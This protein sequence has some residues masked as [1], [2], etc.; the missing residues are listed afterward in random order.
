MSIVSVDPFRCR[1]WDLHD[2]LEGA[3]TEESCKAEI[4]SFQRH[5]QIVP[6]LGRPTRG[7][8]DY[9]VDLI[10][11]ARR[12]FIARHLGRALSIELRE[13]SDRDALIAMDAENR[14]RIDISPYERGMSYAQWLRD[15]HFRSQEDI[16]RTLKVSAAQV[17]RL[18][19]FARLPAVVVDAFRSPVEICEAWGCEMIDALE[20]PQWR[21]LII[22]RARALGARSPRPQ[23][24]EVYRQLMATCAKGRRARAAGRDQV[25]KSDRGRPLF[26]VRRLR[27][28]VAL[29]LPVDRVPGTTLSAIQRTLAEMLQTSAAE[30]VVVHSSSRLGDE[31]S[32]ASMRRA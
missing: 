26:R 20:R 27:N 28:H 21:P 22:Q 24:I 16:S 29:L 14:Q 9:D 4:E 31:W 12:L 30:A 10:F 15:G 7:R 19:K 8:A 6:A 3:I 5:G 13:I 17:S 32:Q 2:R 25:I 1:M 18:L 23:S 11:G